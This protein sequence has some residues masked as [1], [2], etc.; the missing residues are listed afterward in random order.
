MVGSWAR[1]LGGGATPSVD[2]LSAM[3]LHGNRV[4]IDDALAW[5]ARYWVDFRPCYRMVI[6]L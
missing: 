2:H 1:C 4:I 3:V 6:W 5:M